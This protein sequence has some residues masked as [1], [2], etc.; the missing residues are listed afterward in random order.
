[1]IRRYHIVAISIRIVIN[2]FGEHDPDGIMYVLKENEKRVK[3]EVAR[4]PFT[5]VELVQPLVIRANVE[6]D[7]E[8]LFENKLPFNTSIHIQRAEYNVETSD[9]AFVGCNRDSTAPPCPPG[10]KQIYRWHVIR[11]GINFFSDL[12]NPLA[13]EFGS[14]VHGL[15][16]ALIV[17]PKGSTWTDPVTGKP[18]NSGVFADE[19]G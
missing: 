18:I 5:P 14:N 9:G 8:I 13:S 6:D 3:E 2:N 10:G 1:M 16:G 11:E 15:F 17:Q 12:G 4:N 7:I 19:I